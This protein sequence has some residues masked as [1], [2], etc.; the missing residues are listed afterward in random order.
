MIFVLVSLFIFIE[1]NCKELVLVY[2]FV[3][4]SLLKT[5][6]EKNSLVWKM[7]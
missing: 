3:L 5:K 6:L 7:C 2:A 1:T 4:T